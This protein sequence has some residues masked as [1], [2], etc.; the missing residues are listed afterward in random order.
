LKTNLAK[1]YLFRWILHNQSDASAIPMLRA[2]IPALKYGARVLINDH[3][4]SE[5]GK[6]RAW[7]EK[8]MRTMDLVMLTLLNAQERTAGDFEELFRK[9]DERFVFKGVTRP[10]GCRMSIVEAIWNGE[11]ANGQNTLPPN[12]ERI[13]EI[14][15]PTWI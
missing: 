9:A 2:L 5:P 7:D 15:T 1:V 14:E 4:L 12:V 6:E 3:V 10:K 13:P 11:D 8:I